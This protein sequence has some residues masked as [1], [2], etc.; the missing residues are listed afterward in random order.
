MRH[1]SFNVRI[2]TIPHISSYIS[3]TKGSNLEM[4]T[5]IVVVLSSLIY[6]SNTITSQQFIADV[7]DKW[8]VNILMI[9]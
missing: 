7:F 5:M 9:H 4:K 3:L 8:L 2:I 6:S 1:T